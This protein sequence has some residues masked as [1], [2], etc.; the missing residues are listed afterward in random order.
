M[1]KN[2]T[3]TCLLVGIRILSNVFEISWTY[4]KNRLSSIKSNKIKQIWQENDWIWYQTALMVMRDRCTINFYLL[5]YKQIV[6]SCYISLKRFHF[7]IL[8][9]K[10]AILVLES[11]VYRIT[12]SRKEQLKLRFD[13]M[14]INLISVMQYISER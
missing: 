12:R 7:Y 6:Y 14:R 11:T 13:D 5:N 9:I 1:K 3:K 4:L 2:F 10:N 8:Y